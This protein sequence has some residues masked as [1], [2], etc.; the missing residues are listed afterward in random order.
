MQTVVK[1]WGNSLAL[2]L[3]QHMVADLQI[4]EGA[5]VSLA[6]EDHS[7]VVRPTRKRYKLADLL[8]QHAKNGEVRQ[9]ETDW[10]K[11]VGEEEW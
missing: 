7:I 4:V 8:A 1:K 11:P 10:G 5:T 3:P 9:G 6:V 2:R